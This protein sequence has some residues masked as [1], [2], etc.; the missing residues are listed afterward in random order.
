M[1]DILIANKYPINREEVEA[2][3][4]V[5]INNFNDTQHIQVLGK[6]ERLEGM[7]Y[8][9][10]TTTIELALVPAEDTF[11]LILEFRVQKTKGAKPR[12]YRLQASPLVR[13]LTVKDCWHTIYAPS[14]GSNL[15]T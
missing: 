10:L 9:K 3:I 11:P 14:L 6:R 7:L 1:I 8:I 5:D 2:Q 13:Y 4:Q 15:E 12:H